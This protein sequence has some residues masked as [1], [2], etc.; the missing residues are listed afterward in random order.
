[1]DQFLEKHNLSKL[2]PEETDYLNRLISIKETELIITNHP[3][4]KALR[5][6]GF[7]GE[8]CQTF[9]KENNLI[10]SNLFQNISRRWKQKDVSRGWGCVCVETRIYENSLYFPLNF[11][12]SLKLLFK[13]F[14][15]FKKAKFKKKSHSVVLVYWLLPGEAQNFI[16]R[17]SMGK[18]G[19]LSTH[20]SINS[21]I[22]SLTQSTAIPTTIIST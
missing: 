22:Y 17:W 21:F 4:Q 2:T 5:P 16:K 10:H 19:L 18:L 20:P 12:L 11:S 3:K 6:D 8:F 7:T 1:M 14:I 13:Q 9:K 15:N